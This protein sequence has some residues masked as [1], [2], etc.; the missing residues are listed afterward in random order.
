MPVASYGWYYVTPPG[1]DPALSLYRELL[2]LER[3]ERE[4]GR[5]GATA[6]VPSYVCTFFSIEYSS[7]LPS[8]FDPLSTTESKNG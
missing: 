5:E 7:L 8:A 1:T 3:E 2:V 4:R 6:R